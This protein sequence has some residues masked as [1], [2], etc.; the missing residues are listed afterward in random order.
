MN[1]RTILLTSVFALSLLPSIAVAAEAKSETRNEDG[2]TPLMRAAAYGT[3]AEVRELL[4]K[5]SDPNAK[6]AS[7][8]TA[9]LFAIT[10]EAKVRALLDKGADVNIQTRQGRTPLHAAASV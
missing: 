2:W 4:K 5:G 10:D 8:A 3:A 1:P 6:N 9:L 7:G